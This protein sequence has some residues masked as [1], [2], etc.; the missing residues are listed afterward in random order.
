MVYLLFFIFLA[1]PK[2]REL[3]SFKV[4]EEAFNVAELVGTKYSKLGIFLLKDETG[5]I[6][7]ALKQEH[8]L[9]SEEIN[10]AIFRKWLQGK[11][12][13]PVAWSTL[14]GVLREIDLC[15]LADAIESRLMSSSVAL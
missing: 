9:N 15:T 7:Q 3:L 13:Q 5:A 12:A 2:L 11:G 1:K 8:L 4:K 10:M 6:V 14:I